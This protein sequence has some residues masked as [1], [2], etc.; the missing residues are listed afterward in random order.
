MNKGLNPTNNENIY[1]YLTNIPDTM[2]QF[3]P[4]HNYW[5]GGGMGEKLIQLIKPLWNGFQK[6]WQVNIMDKML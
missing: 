6:N 1:I 2:H 5:E 4:I 3:G